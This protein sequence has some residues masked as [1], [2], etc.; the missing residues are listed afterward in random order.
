MSD[1]PSGLS[2]RRFLKGALLVGAGG[3]GVGLPLLTQLSA[4]AWP[5]QQAQATPGA[6]VA[7]S[8]TPAAGATPAIGQQPPPP[9]GTTAQRMQQTAVG[10]MRFLNQHEAETVQAIS[11]RLIPS[12]DLGPG[13]IEAGAVTYIDG[14]LDSGWGYGARWYMQGPFTNGLAGQGKQS[15]LIP[16]DI[17]RIGLK[18]LDAYTLKRYGMAF[19][20]LTTA[21]QDETLAAIEKPPA[22]STVN[23][24]FTGPTAGE[25]FGTVLANVRE[26]MFADPLYGGNQNMVGW[27]LVG[28]PGAHFHYNDVILLYGVPFTEAPQSLATFVRTVGGAIV[29]PESMKAEGPNSQGSNSPGMNMPGMSGNGR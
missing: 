4:A 9:G 13:A 24:F 15:P 23:Q 12:D 27:Q 22:G 16:R 19:K 10:A 28:F 2:R 21:Q 8:G 25:F 11:G 17:Y 14:Q 29:Y 5:A 7:A 3:A 18:Q 6:T 20:D 26:G 1:S